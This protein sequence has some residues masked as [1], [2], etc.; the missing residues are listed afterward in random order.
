M[1]PLKQNLRSILAV[2]ILAALAV[3]PLLAGRSGGVFLVNFGS[4]IMIFAIAAISLD[5]LLGFG[6]MVSFGHAAYLGLGGYAVAALSFY[7]IDNGW[8]QFALALAGSG[9]FALIVGSIA[10]RTSGVYFIMITLA[11]TQLLFYIGI[12]IDQFGGDDGFSTRRSSFGGGSSMSDPLLLYYV[13][14]A[15]L[16][17]VLAVAYR[18]ADSR[19]GLV[20]R[21]IK[22][23]DRRI[24]A[25]GFSTFRYRLIAF[26]IAGLICGLAGALYVNLKGYMSPVY[27]HWFRSGE[28]IIMV[29][30]GGTGTVIGALLGAT[31]FQV[32]ETFLPVAIDAVLPGRGTN[33]HLLLAPILIF[34]VLFV[35]G[36]LISVIPGRAR[37]P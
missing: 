14:F 22:S 18:L 26:V 8:L 16:A 32:M 21:G 2:A 31:V 20:L 4:R 27:M 3:L 24:A 9:V 23:N 5:L 17:V 12:S 11:L 33:W 36:G 35:P 28:L 15:C 19:F 7:G 29:L 13:C 10:V 30:L 34:I 25:L 1:A 37:G 6:G